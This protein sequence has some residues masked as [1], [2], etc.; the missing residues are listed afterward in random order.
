MIL[1]TNLS[2]FKKISAFKSTIKATILFSFLAMPVGLIGGFANAASPTDSKVSTSKKS[3][4][5]F[6][7]FASKFDR[8]N[9]F[10]IASFNIREIATPENTDYFEHQMQIAN[11]EFKETGSGTAGDVIG[12]I[13]KI[14]ATDGA[15][16]GAWVTL[17]EKLWELIVANKP[18]VNVSSQRI[19]VLP[20]NQQD[21]RQMEQWQVPASKTY[22]FEAKNGFGMT[23]IK[24]AYTLT[25]NYGGKFQGKGSYLANATIIPSE[26]DVLWGYTLNSKVIVAEPVNL[27]TL[28]NQ[29]PGVELQIKWSI[30]T[31]VKHSEQSS[32]YFVRG[33]G[34]V[35]NITP[36]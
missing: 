21:W 7:K 22:V 30:D 1:S 15:D 18:V 17:G 26:I 28:E 24:H 19:S 23:V 27:G 13:G 8:D 3:H 35:V 32:S 33:D 10:S 9:Y 31:V 6:G 5:A 25:F 12:S 16:I 36:H 4:D 11:R 2:S 20:A 34:Q 14:I 29:I